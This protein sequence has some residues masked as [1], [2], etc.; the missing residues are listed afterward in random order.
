MNLSRFCVKTSFLYVYFAL[1][2]CSTARTVH[3]VVKVE[4]AAIQDVDTSTD[5]VCLAGD[6]DCRPSEKLTEAE[7]GIKSVNDADDDTNVDNHVEG[8]ADDDDDDDDYD[9][10]YDYDYYNVEEDDDDHADKDD[11]LMVED[12]EDK[13]AIECTDSHDQCNFW[14]SLGECEKN[15]KYM[16]ENCQ[17]S[18]KTCKDARAPAFAKNYGE[19]QECS[20]ENEKELLERVQKMDKYM[21][22]VVSAP[23]YDKVRSECKNRHKLCVYW[24]FLGECEANENYM[25]INCAPSCETCKQIDYDYRCPRD[26]NE[27]DSLEPGDLESMFSRITSEV[28][29]VTVLSKPDSPNEDGSE[30]S[31]SKKSPWVSPM[32][33]M[34]V[35]AT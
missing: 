27:K 32:N 28:E 12:Q 4:T 10:D 29:Y 23:E 26:P 11:G 1:L 6:Q 14:A 13:N 35:F 34:L 3:G 33:F 5:Q 25:L 19:T 20:G 9:Y 18:C 7:V 17:A 8:R 15:P 2:I 21:K 30:V 24:A 31:K 16:L 22:E